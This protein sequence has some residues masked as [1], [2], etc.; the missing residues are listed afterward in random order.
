MTN[1]RSIYSVPIVAGVIACINPAV[2]SGEELEELA[3][4]YFRDPF[5][6]SLSVSPDG[7]HFAFFQ[8][9]DERT[10]LS[11]FNIEKKEVRSFVGLEGQDVTRYDWVDDD[12]L[13]FQISRSDLPSLDPRG[14]IYHAGLGTADE[15]IERVNTLTEDLPISLLVGA[16]KRPGKALGI[17]R[18]Q[19][20]K[21]PD[22]VSID[23]VDD[24]SETEVENTLKVNSWKIDD[25][26]IVRLGKVLTEESKN[27]WLHRFTE[28]SPWVRLNLPEYS[29]ALAFDNTGMAL[30]V[31]HPQGRNTYALNVFDLKENRFIGP[32]FTDPEYDICTSSSG[33]IRDQKHN[34]AVGFR[35]EREKP[36][37]VYFNDDY[38]NLQKKINAALPNSYNYILGLTESGYVVIRVESDIIPPI[39]YL[40]DPKSGGLMPFLP[41]RKWLDS[42][43]LSPMEP[44]S[45][46]SRDGATLY[47]YLTL[48]KGHGAGPMPLIL[49]I[50]GGP[51]G[52]DTW[53]FDPEVQFF[54]KLGYAVF[55]VNYRGST[56]YGKIYEGQDLLKVCRYSIDDVADAA[57]WAIRE[58]Y[59]DPNRIAIFGE[60][61]G[62]YAALAG[63][64]FEPELYRCAIG[65]AGIYDWVMKMKVDS[66][67]WRRRDLFA[68]RDDY[69][70]DFKEH[71]D[72]YLAVSPR[73]AAEKIRIPVL[74]IHGGSDH[75]VSAGQAKAM[76]AALRKAKKPHEIKIYPWG[77]KGFLNPKSRINYYVKV[78]EF[79]DKH[80][81]VE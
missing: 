3:E 60:I 69:Y 29:H 30:Y 18:K 59:A 73:F 49:N 51:Q 40:L 24:L 63:A 43:E 4:R 80:M 79:I 28:E 36:T 62:G 37:T 22:V 64:T 78:A 52:R 16:R 39:C 65:F 12:N 70:P 14:R 72:E 77:G 75:A 19:G 15:D 2:A 76:R 1:Y 53:G 17:Y 8:Y 20:Q 27:H 9:R 5:F 61:F 66:K 47:G 10:I 48:P 32:S 81:G 7:S 74:L 55:Q 44:V 58:N 25:D 38:L 45:F 56:G 23:I 68:W 57:R 54:A 41:S 71:R 35:S 42:D 21:Y 11:T 34:F 67:D 33:L 6:E 13:I 31:C 46:P 26:G 50:H